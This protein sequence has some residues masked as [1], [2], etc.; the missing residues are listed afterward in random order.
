MDISTITVPIELKQIFGKMHFYDLAKAI[1]LLALGFLTASLIGAI[2]TK[3]LSKHSSVH[4]TVL[5]R[6]FSYGA[7]LFIF[8]LSAIQ[9]LGFDITALL[10]AA[11][12]L[13]VAVGFAAR[14]PI[15]NMISGIFLVFEQPFIIGDYLE[16][17]KIQGE[18][19]SIDLLSIKIRTL[20]NVL[21]RIPN[22]ELVTKQFFNL[23]RFPIRRLDL[24][25]RIAFDEKVDRVRQVLFAIAKQNSLSLESPS[26]NLYFDQYTDSAMVYKFVVWAKQSSFDDLKKF[27]PEQIQQAFLDNGIQM[28]F[29]QSTVHF[30]ESFLSRYVVPPSP[31]K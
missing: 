31:A 30:S 25:I 26:A 8:I 19:L 27:L 21:M 9:T 2:I 22:E 29:A 28:P 14:T 5:I 12:I 11:G 6:R 4:Y 7:T 10:G 16:V 1:I 20:D 23:T 24:Y 15:S 3:T 17:N 18:V 13:T